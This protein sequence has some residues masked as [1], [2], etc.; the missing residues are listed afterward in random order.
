MPTRMT[1]DPRVFAITRPDPARGD[2]QHPYRNVL[3]IEYEAEVR[4]V[5]RVEHEVKVRNILGVGNEASG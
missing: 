3:G 5:I 2:P 4:H 1:R